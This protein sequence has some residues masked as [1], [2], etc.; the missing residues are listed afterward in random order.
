MTFHYRYYRDGRLPQGGYNY[1][2]ESFY[3]KKIVEYDH[4]IGL[5]HAINLAK[6]EIKIRKQNAE[7]AKKQI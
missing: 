3:G 5:Q 6:V 1:Y 4:G 7:E 2:L